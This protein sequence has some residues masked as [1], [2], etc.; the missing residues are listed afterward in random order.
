VA[1]EFQVEDP[2]GH[3]LRFGSEPQPGAP[4]GQ[5]R[6]LRGPLGYLP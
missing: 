4:S 2:N 1:Y 5:F 3:V 6:V